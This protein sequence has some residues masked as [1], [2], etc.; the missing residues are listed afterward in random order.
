MVS[1]SSIRILLDTNIWRKIFFSKSPLASSLIRILILYKGKVIFPEVI[2]LELKQILFRDGLDYRSSI[3]KSNKNLFSLLDSDNALK[4]PSDDEIREAIDKKLDSLQDF[5]ERIP[6]KID[7][8]KSA[9]TRVIEKKPPNSQNKEQFRDS[10]IWEVG[11]DL[12]NSHSVFFVT[13]D[14]DFFSD[15]KQKSFHTALLDECKKVSFRLKPYS[16]LAECLKELEGIGTI[17]DTTK[18]P[19]LI[20]DIIK[21]D[22]DFVLNQQE[23]KILNLDES[24]LGI[25][26]ESELGIFEMED[27]NQRAIEFTLVFPAENLS[28]EERTSPRVEIK[29]DGL[30][31]V[32]DNSLSDVELE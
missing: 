1:N 13:E 6:L 15:K 26:D 16:T 18:L 4:L 5:I 8:V 12:T 21:K 28:S 22:F 20:I 24:G 9:L 10:L 25:L 7:H 17:E 32:K 3:E 23:F 30:F 14:G 11:L 19:R 2:E 29:G 31:S 27:L